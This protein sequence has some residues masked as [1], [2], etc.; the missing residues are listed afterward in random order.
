VTSVAGTLM[1]DE[2]WE[3][4]PGMCI[5]QKGWEELVSG[6]TYVLS[7]PSLGVRLFLL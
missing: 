6:I 5:T 2:L 4:L 3:K 1:V 7:M